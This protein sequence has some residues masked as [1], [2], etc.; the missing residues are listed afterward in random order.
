MRKFEGDTVGGIRGAGG[1]VEWRGSSVRSEG[2][3]L[4]VDGSVV[5]SVVVRRS[6]GK[7]AVG[8]V[9]SEG[10]DERGVEDMGR[11]GVSAEG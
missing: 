8:H 5:D 6:W 10:E 11:R 3:H 2:G 9:D 4:D 1:W 7:V